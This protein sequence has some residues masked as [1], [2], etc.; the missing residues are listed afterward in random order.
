[1]STALLV[2]DAQEAP[3]SGEEIA[4]DIV[5]VIGRINIVLVKRVSR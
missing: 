5:A 3:R 4:H 2:I 1:M